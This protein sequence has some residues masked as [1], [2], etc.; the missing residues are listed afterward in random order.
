SARSLPTS[1][2][3][4]LQPQ[5]RSSLTR[6]P[7]SARPS[8]DEKQGGAVWCVGY[9]AVPSESFYELGSEWRRLCEP[10]SFCRVSNGRL[11]SNIS[12]GHF[13]LTT[14]RY[15]HWIIR[16][17]VIDAPAGAVA[18]INAVNTDVPIR[19]AP[20]TITV[21]SIALMIIAHM[22]ATTPALGVSVTKSSS[23]STRS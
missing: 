14:S 10:H 13:R 23:R 8:L 4:I 9:R 16:W 6:L 17:L 11:E 15:M 18:K 7:H 1:A 19:I 12:R 2:Q 22:I 21:D 5:N 20:T 3:P